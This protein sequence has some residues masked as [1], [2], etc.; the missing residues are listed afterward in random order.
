MSQRRP[1]GHPDLHLVPTKFSFSHLGPA[2][3][4]K[5]KGASKPLAVMVAYCLILAPFVGVAARTAFS[6]LA[7]LSSMFIFHSA[8]I[9]SLAS[10]RS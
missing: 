4:T 2:M 10:N 1:G 9:A 3:L 5:K 6:N 7:S 8:S